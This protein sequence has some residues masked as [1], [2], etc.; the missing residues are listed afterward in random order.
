MSVN[1]LLND[2]HSQERANQAQ[3]RALSTKWQKKLPKF[4]FYLK[5]IF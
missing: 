2:S 3:S 5:Y 1:E 4:K